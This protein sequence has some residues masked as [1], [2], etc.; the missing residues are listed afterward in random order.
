VAEIRIIGDIHGNTD[1][2]LDIIKDAKYS[3]QLGDFNFDYSCMENISQEHLIVGG[4]HDNYDIIHTCPNYLGDYGAAQQGPFQ[5]FF[6]RGAFSIDVDWRKK[7]ELV[8]GGRIWWENEQLSAK[9]MDDC[10]ELYKDVKPDVVLSHSCPAFVA[11]DVGNASVLK[12]FGYGENFCT[13]TQL[14]LQ[15]LYEQHEPK[16][17]CFGHFHRNWWKWYGSTRFYCIGA[18]DW[19]DFNEEWNVIGGN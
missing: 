14:L 10:V 3:V 18:C 11:Q 17:W 2:Y 12:A 5:F 13:N 6:V 19:L 1:K 8:N 9:Q 16:I 15:H 7:Y 4:N